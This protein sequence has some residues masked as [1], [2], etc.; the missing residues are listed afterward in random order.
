MQISPPV[1]F[2]ST[3]T[4]CVFRRRPPAPNCRWIPARVD[5]RGVVPRAGLDIALALAAPLVDDPCPTRRRPTYRY[6]CDIGSRTG[7][8]VPLRLFFYFSLISAGSR[9]LNPRA[10]TTG[11]PRP[12]R[13]RPH[14]PCPRSHPWHP[15]PHPHPHSSA[16]ARAHAHAH[17]HPQP[18]RLC[19]RCV[20]PLTPTLARAPAPAH[21][22]KGSWLWPCLGSGGAGG[23]ASA[24]PSRSA[25]NSASTR[26]QRLPCVRIRRPPLFQLPVVQQNAGPARVAG[27]AAAT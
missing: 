12:L 21:A 26:T 9:L 16:L 25:T 6:A 20:P 2:L 10:H 17:A 22:S 18:P 24:P 1:P 13:L 4:S 23:G 27:L 15:R 14:R 8:D 7:L 3:T 11:H 5:T 19:P